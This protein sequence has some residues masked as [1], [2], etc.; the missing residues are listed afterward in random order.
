MQHNALDHRRSFQRQTTCND[1]HA[2]WKAH[3]PQH[4][5]TEHARVSDLGPRVEIRVEPENLHGRFR[6]W[7]VCRL[8]S[9]VCDAD[10][11]EE[12]L[13]Q[14]DEVAERQVV[15]GHKELDLVE[16]GKVSCV[17]GLVPE[18]AVDGEVPSQKYKTGE[19]KRQ[20]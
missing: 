20:K 18:H 2:F 14:R 17:H 1:L 7:V 5:R 8:E 15:V 3:G 12:S 6:I 9:Q 11:V 16:L 13:Q 19:A 4:L 10:F